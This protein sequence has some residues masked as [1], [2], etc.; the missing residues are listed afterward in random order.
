M[1]MALWGV[2][3]LICTRDARGHCLIC[4]RDARGRVRTYPVVHRECVHISRA[5]HM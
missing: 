5:S 2:H 1:V 3:C 4:M